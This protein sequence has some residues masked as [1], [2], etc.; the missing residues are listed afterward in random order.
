MCL[1]VP[2][3]SGFSLARRG[4]GPLPSVHGSWLSPS[5]PQALPFSL[6]CSS[7]PPGI[8][9]IL[10]LASDPYFCHQCRGPTADLIVNQLCSQEQVA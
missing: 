9:L 5:S 7:P 8:D 1:G 6:S 2:P 10:A 4:W 3:A